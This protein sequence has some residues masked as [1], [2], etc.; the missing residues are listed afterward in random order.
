MDLLPPFRPTPGPE[1]CANAPG[2]SRWATTEGLCR[3]HYGKRERQRLRDLKRVLDH[4]R[5]EALRHLDM[6]FP[7]PKRSR[8]G[9][10]QLEALALVTDE[11]RRAQSAF[12]YQVALVARL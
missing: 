8:P 12:D 9:P 7:T 4:R 6:S 3:M 2:C 5:A 10:R 1:R 11:V